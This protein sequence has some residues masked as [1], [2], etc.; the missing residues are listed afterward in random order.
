MRLLVSVSK[1]TGGIIHTVNQVVGLIL[2]SLLS[3]IMSNSTVNVTK[4]QITNGLIHKMPVIISVIQ[5]MV[6][7]LIMD[8]NLKIVFVS[9]T[10]NGADRIRHAH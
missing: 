8:L 7:N 10:I 1:I 2:D 3:L 4:Q 9:T 6:H 5:L